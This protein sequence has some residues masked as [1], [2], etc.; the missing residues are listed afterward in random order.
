MNYEKR[1]AISSAWIKALDWQFFYQ[2][3]GDIDK[4]QLWA[5]RAAKLEKRVLSEDPNV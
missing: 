4:A 2:R 1:H 3:C 5:K